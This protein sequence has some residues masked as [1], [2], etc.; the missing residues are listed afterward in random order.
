VREYAQ[1]ELRRD[2]QRRHRE[3]LVH[4]SEQSDQ[5]TDTSRQRSVL[6]LQQSAGNTAVSALL[7]E[8][9][10][11]RVAD[12]PAVSDDMEA[13]READ[14]IADAAVAKMG[15]AAQHAPTVGTALSPTLRR[16]LAA[17]APDV[18]A[19]DQVRVSTD[20]EASSQADSIDARAFTHGREVSVA[21]GELDNHRE[22]HRLLA[23]EAVHAARHQPAAGGEVVHA[24][25]RGTRDAMVNMGGGETTSKSRK[26]VNLLTNWDQ[27]VESLGA[28][29]ELEAALLKGGNPS[30]TALAKVKPKMLKQLGRV[31]AACL[32]W[33][34]ANKGESKKRTKE[35]QDKLITG[36][37]SEQ[38]DD[39]S[40]AERRQAI[41][42][43]LPR[44][45]TEMADITNGKWA[46]SLGLS[47][48]QMVGK[49]REDK[50]SINPVKELK[51]A[52]ESGEFSG[53]FKAEQGFAK[54]MQGHEADVGIPQADP[55]YGKRVVAMYRLDQLLGAEVTVRSEFA[56]HDGVLGTVGETAVGTKGS[57]TLFA[58]DDEEKAALGP[59]AVLST[60]PVLQRALNKLQILDAICGQ[61]DRHNNNWVV[62]TDD[63]G[64]VKGVKGIDLDMA[65]G[66]DMEDI[67]RNTHRMGE[68]YRGL[69]P[70]I[71]E[72]FALKVI[73]VKP[74]D[75]RN[76]VKGLLSDKEVEA[77]VSR[78]K[79]VVDRINRIPREE[80]VKNWD[81]STSLK[82]RETKHTTGGDYKSYTAKVTG[83]TVDNALDRMDEEVRYALTGAKASTPF[84]PQLAQRL[85]VLPP[86]TVEAITDC[87]RTNI[88]ALTRDK[89]WDATIPTGKLI[90]L[91]MEM[92][93]AALGDNGAMSQAELTA[94]THTD[95]ATGLTV[96]L[97]PIFQPKLETFLNGWLARQR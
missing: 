78:F 76:C 31:E 54:K 67:E 32:A 61:L 96:L 38:E 28:Y 74:E 88:R 79:K 3:Q 72:E 94:M 27:I 81:K 6:E 55:N 70:I 59:N 36:Q 5:V 80:L 29:E 45:R 33:E 60:D 75:I 49:G 40:K 8:R 34:K 20:R 12:T 52:T 26:R 24:K 47:D 85:R 17:V 25:R 69:P 2:D 90:P 58:N 62:E 1:R 57:E 89:V 22:G 77:T 82:N 86:K 7:R 84:K 21:R 48:K 19:L 10:P 71:D 42:M 43:L 68:N 9:A 14:R 65:F 63:K 66:G 41:S 51:Y 44:I 30:P 87:L 15:P 37:G 13:E 39:R 53:Y 4:E 35:R 91:A 83:Q 64:G 18:G 23:H 73:A 97:Y 46:Q 93:N 56:T 95:K 11:K 16:A 92:L 50:G